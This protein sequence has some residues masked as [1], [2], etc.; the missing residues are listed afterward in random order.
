MGALRAV[1]KKLRR[2]SITMTGNI[3]RANDGLSSL[4]NTTVDFINAYRYGE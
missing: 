3:R 1:Y 4:D 2:E